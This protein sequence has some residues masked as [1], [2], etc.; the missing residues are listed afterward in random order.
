MRHPKYRPDIDGMRAIAVISVVLFHAFPGFMKGGF[1]GVDVFFVISGF[2]I[3]SIIIGSLQE[4]RF[5]FLTFYSRRINRI[6]PALLV[7][8]LSCWAFGWMVLFPEELKQL[9]K[10]IAGGASFVSNFV[11][12]AESGYFDNS[13]DSKVLLHLWSLGIE[14][15]FYLIWPLVLWAAYKLRFNIL[16]LTLILAVTSF[17][18]NIATMHENAVSAFYSPHTR[19]WELLAGTVLA[20][21]TLNRPKFLDNARA[22]AG[23]IYRNVLSVGGLALVLLAFVLI[24]KDH[25]FPGWWALLPVMGSV[26]LIAAGPFALLNRTLLSSRFMVGVGLISFPLYLWHW[27]LLTYARIIEGDTPAA[28][29]RWSAVALSVVLAWLTY[30]LLETPLKH[31]NG[32]SKPLAL[33]ALMI[34]MGLIGFYTYSKDGLPERPVAKHTSSVSSQFVGPAWA[35][36]RSPACEARYPYPDAADFS[37]WFCME[38]KEA[39]PTLMLIGT[40]FANQ[41]FPGLAKNPAT[42]HHSILSIGTCDPADFVYR[43]WSVKPHPCSEDRAEKQTAFISSIIDKAGTVQYAILDGLPPDPYEGY[44]QSLEKYIGELEKKNV[45][46][47]VFLPHMQLGVDPRSCFARPFGGTANSCKLSYEKFLDINRKW[48]PIISLIEQSHPDTR[49]FDQKVL[50]CKDGACSATLDDMPMFRDQTHLSEFA[51]IRLAEL[52]VEWAKVNAPGILG[53]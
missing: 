24:N 43:Q 5:S 8:L 47:I 3:G 29:I 15:Q 44:A 49:F 25:S 38:S 21:L 14:E 9:G 26:M 20:H 50:T 1:V 13:S 28:W 41:L 27:P 35:Y 17:G 19:F 32:R 36:M 7:V 37:W 45:K 6:F 22:S 33:A 53:K 16:A 30:R 31:R 51:S 42:E 10:H 23:P 2:L 48:A 34:A 4:E 39:P 18:L 52:F 40:S 12:L 11:L 46:V